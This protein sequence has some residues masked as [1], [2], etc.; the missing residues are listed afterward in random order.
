[1]ETAQ[2]LDLISS[3]TKLDASNLEPSRVPKQPGLYVWYSK[4]TGEPAYVGS[5]VG[6]NGLRRRICQQ[7][8]NPRYLEKRPT[9]LGNKDWY[10][11]ENPILVNDVIAVDKSAFRKNVARKHQL[12]AGKESVGYLKDN[13]CV[14]FM[15]LQD[16]EKN[17]LL[18][19]ENEAIKVLNPTYN[20]RGKALL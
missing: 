9:K 13:F 2:L 3:Q 19:L 4:A 11:L 17:R 14:S 15:V 1:M 18:E 20:L 16:C 7:H 6:E 12:K 10:Q 5:A 8:L